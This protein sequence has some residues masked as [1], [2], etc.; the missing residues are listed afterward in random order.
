MS[1][2]VYL[3]ICT[4]EILYKTYIISRSINNSLYNKYIIK[5]YTID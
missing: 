1:L 5:T 4:L 2:P 3:Y